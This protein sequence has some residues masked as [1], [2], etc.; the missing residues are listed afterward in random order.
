MTKGTDLAP[1]GQV[2]VCAACGKRARSQYGFDA[3]GGRTN[4]DPR[5]DESCAMLALLVW[6]WA[7][8]LED[9]GGGGLTGVQNRAGH[10]G[11]YG[12][13]SGFIKPIGFM[14]PYVPA[15]LD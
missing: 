12:N 14:I 5:W 13:S 15:Q 11:N 8:L 2:W 6:R 4:I 9:E 3:S 7:G 10:A 1:A